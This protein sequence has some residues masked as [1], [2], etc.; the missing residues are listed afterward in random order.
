MTPAAR[1]R[2]HALSCALLLAGVV[3]AL[4]YVDAH[5]T[6]LV[7]ASA[8]RFSHA[9]GAYDGPLVLEIASSADVIYTLDGSIP[10][11]EAHQR[12]EHPLRFEAG[13]VVVLRARTLDRGHLGPTVTRHYVVGLDAHLPV[14]SLAVEPADLWGESQ[15]Y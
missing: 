1:R 5:H 9:S 12:Y 11:L 14:L 10:T 3:G 13:D 2:L 6:P 4:C 8:L 15:Q 7:S